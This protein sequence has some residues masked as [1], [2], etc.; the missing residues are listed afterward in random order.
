[1]LQPEINH[2]LRSV[3]N[4]EAL[5]GTSLIPRKTHSMSEGNWHSASELNDDVDP[6][7]LTARHHTTITIQE[8]P[9][10]PVSAQQKS[11]RKKSIGCKI[12]EQALKAASGYT[13]K[14]DKYGMYPNPN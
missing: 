10:E 9:E 1:M 4:P 12:G 11:D 14:K 5:R 2:G 3:P 8:V 13:E 6:R 7:R